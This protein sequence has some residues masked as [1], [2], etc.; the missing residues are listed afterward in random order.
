VQYRLQPQERINNGTGGE[1]ISYHSSFTSKREKKGG[2]RMNKKVLMMT[3]VLLAM[4]ILT[5]VPVQAKP[6]L[7]FLLHI[8]G[9]DK[10]PDYYDRMWESDDVFHVRG[11]EFAIWGDFYIL[12]DETRIDL[13]PDDYVARTRAVVNWNYKTQRLTVHL[14]ETISIEYM[15]FE[16]TIEILVSDKLDFATRESEGTFVGHG[17]GDFEGVKVRGETSGYFD[18]DKMMSIFNREGTVMGW[19]TQ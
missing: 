7:Y 15:D 11:G 3:L 9:D 19:P 6:K 5:I 2:E 8:E 1:Y 14:K 4:P 18:Y 16:G 17:T 10:G 12:I 13:D